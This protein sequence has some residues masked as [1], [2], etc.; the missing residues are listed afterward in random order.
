P[1]TSASNL[2][3]VFLILTI[4]VAE[5]GGRGAALATA[6]VS[7]MTLNF[8]LTEPYLTLA[9]NKPDDLIAFFALGASGLVAAAFGKRRRKLSDEVAR[10]GQ[11][12][13]LLQNLVQQLR[14]KSSLQGVL[15]NLRRSFKLKG[16]VLRDSKE[17]ILA[18]S[19]AGFSPEVPTTQL[20]LNT[21]LPESET[22]QRFGT[23]GLRLPEQGGRFSLHTDRGVLSLD[24]W[25]GDPQGFELDEGQ[26]LAIAA[27]VL[28]LESSRYPAVG[29]KS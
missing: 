17:R 6:I 18:A 7:A 27:S 4:V 16:I 8:C 9:I 22:V 13:D 19:P 24:M 3:F 12:L 28:I 29:G 2:A 15:G 26:T 5:L 20:A 23:K 25:E 1:L 10:A 14:E 11:R 21:L